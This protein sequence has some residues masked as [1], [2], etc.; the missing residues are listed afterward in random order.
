MSY[1]PQEN[2]TGKKYWLSDA[3]KFAGKFWD[4]SPVPGGRMETFLR[5][6]W[7]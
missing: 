3:A 1:S 5:E 2:K 4:D 7:G 6:K